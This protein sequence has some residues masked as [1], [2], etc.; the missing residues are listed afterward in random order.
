MQKNILFVDIF[1]G[2]GSSNWL[3]IIQNVFG[4]L[5]KRLFAPLVMKKEN[6]ANARHDSTLPVR[7]ILFS[8]HR[9]SHWTVPLSPEHLCNFRSLRV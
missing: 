5:R 2:L 9:G 3:R 7:L 6:F 8:V 4:A 1:A